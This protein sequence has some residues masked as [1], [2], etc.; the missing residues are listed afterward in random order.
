MGGGKLD[1]L[2]PARVEGH[3]IITVAKAYHWVKKE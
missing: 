2:F 1:S 3:H